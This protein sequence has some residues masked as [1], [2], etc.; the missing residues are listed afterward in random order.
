MEGE[1]TLGDIYEEIA[2]RL[3]EA[4]TRALMGERQNALSLFRGA[5][6]EYQRFRDVLAEYPGFHALEH[7]FDVTMTALQD[8]LD[9]PEPEAPE[10]SDIS[11]PAEAPEKPARSRRRI[12]TAA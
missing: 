5:K 8:E 11:E 4:R 9:A 2:E 6:L 3:A 10:S 7:A 1:F 12:R